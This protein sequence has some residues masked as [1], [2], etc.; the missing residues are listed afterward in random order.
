M[1]KTSKKNLKIDWTFLR[2]EPHP[3]NISDPYRIS[4]QFLQFI[5][6]DKTFYQELVL[7]GLNITFALWA[8]I[9]LFQFTLDWRL[10]FLL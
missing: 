6:S 4:F 2:I 3:M 9:I 10:S 1:A 7:G 5:P 8:P